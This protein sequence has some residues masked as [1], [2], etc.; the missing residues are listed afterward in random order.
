MLRKIR[1]LQFLLHLLFLIFSI[2]LPQISAQQGARDISTENVVLI[3]L[4]GLRWQEIFYGADRDLLRSEEFTHDTAAARKLFWDEDNHT[5]RKKLFPFIWDTVYTRGQ[6]YGN[7]S[8]GNKV[9]LTNRHKV[10]YPGYNEILTGAAD[11]ERIKNNGDLLNPNINIL[12]AADS[13]KGIKTAAFTSWN[14]FVLILNQPRNGIYINAG[15]MP[16]AGEVLSGKEYWLNDLLASTP[17]RWAPVRLDAFTYNYA[18][19]YMKREKPRFVFISLGETDEFAHEGNYMQ[20]LLSAGSG[21]RFI[22]ELWAWVQSDSFYSNKTTF[23]ITTDHGRGKG[24]KWKDHGNKASE[25]GETWIAV[26][27]PDTYNGGEMG[28]GMQLYMNQIA[29]TIAALLKI[30]FDSG[31]KKGKPIIPIFTPAH[32]STG[33]TAPSTYD[34]A[35]PSR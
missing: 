20:Y 4:D 2:P 3:T 12:E 30:E 13:L 23:I 10:S 16:V 18:L 31:E 27:G 15:N 5:R 26:I 11:D 6:L 21:S 33:K 35:S 25:S 19:E 32:N 34:T 24:R 14:K 8:L 28:D 29:P 9:N 1:S 22:G 7:R 17:H